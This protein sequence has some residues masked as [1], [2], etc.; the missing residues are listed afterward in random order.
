MAAKLIIEKIFCLCS[1][2]RATRTVWRNIAIAQATGSERNR[3]ITSIDTWWQITS[4]RDGRILAPFLKSKRKF[5]IDAL[6]LDSL[7]VAC[8][9]RGL[10][11]GCQK[12][13]GEKT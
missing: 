8:N 7:W 1:E 2:K 5:Q 11:Q 6:L 9:R 13:R 4:G 12:Q 3:L 10:P